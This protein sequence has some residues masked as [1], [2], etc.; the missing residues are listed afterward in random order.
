MEDEMG[1]TCQMHGR[2]EKYIQHF[3]QMTGGRDHLE[4]TG[5]DGKL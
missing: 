2:D 4:D 3:G 5:V 1:R